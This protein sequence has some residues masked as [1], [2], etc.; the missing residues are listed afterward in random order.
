MVEMVVR[1]QNC[2]N[3]IESE[4]FRKEFLLETPGTY[5]GIDEHAMSVPLLLRTQKIAIAATA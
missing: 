2:I 1:H 5:A 3:T 4:A